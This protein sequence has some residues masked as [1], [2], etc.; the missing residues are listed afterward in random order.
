MAKKLFSD[1]L[2]ADMALM[3]VLGNGGFLFDF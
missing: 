3:E 1:R 2:R